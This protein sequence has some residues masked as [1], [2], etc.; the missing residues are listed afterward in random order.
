[1]SIQRFLNQTLC[2]F[3]QIKHRKHIESVARVMPQGWDLWVLAG[4]NFSVGI[5]HGAPLTARSSHCCY[6]C[7][8]MYIVDELLIF[9]SFLFCVLRPAKHKR[10]YDHNLQAAHF[11]QCFD[12]LIFAILHGK[13]QLKMQILAKKMTFYE[14][15]QVFTESINPKLQILIIQTTNYSKGFL[16][17]MVLRITEV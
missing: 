16:W 3:S 2:V 7:R 1:M 14:S 4:Q 10:Q 9:Y 11:C 13:T 17:S 15:L 5:C 8:Y 6:Q 12:R